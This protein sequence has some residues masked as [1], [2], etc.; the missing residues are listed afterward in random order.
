M[1][2][3]AALR[4]WLVLE[5]LAHAD[6]QLLKL[7]RPEHHPAVAPAIEHE[8]ARPV[9][10]AAQLGPNMQSRPA[11]RV[12]FYCHESGELTH[13]VTTD[14]FG[15]GVQLVRDRLPKDADYEIDASWIQGLGE[16]ELRTPLGTPVARVE[17]LSG[18]KVTAQRRV[19]AAFSGLQVGDVAPIAQLFDPVPEAA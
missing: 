13:V 17:A 5:D 8:A 2:D 7:C 9:R 10:P 6:A 3:L 12:S 16:M 1:K 15:A 11:Y 19:I 14:T 4:A 18:G